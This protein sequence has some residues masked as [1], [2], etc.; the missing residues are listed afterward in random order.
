MRHPPP[1]F[2]LAPPRSFTS[3]V[4][5]AIGQHPELYGTPELNLFQAPTVHEFWTGR[6][7]D[8]S[9]RTPFWRIMRHDGILRALAQLYAGEQTMDAVE[10]AKRWLIVRSRRTTAEAHGEICARVGARILVDKSPGYVRRR[11]YLDRIV[12]AFPDARFIH[13]TRHPVGQCESVLSA[14]NGRL[15][16]FFMGAVDNSGA[17][18][19]IDPQNGW[20][21]AHH[22]ILKFLADIPRAR[23][24]RLKGE[25]FMNDIDGGAREVCRWLGVSDAA[26]AIEEMK[27]PE[28]SPFACIGPAG[29]R[30][31]NDP[32]FLKAPMLRPYSVKER[33]LEGPLPWRPDGKG[34][35]TEAI[36]LARYLG[37]E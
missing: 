21:D 14:D 11:E 18:P 3:L 20:R 16:A 22:T 9:L 8:G 29:A 35:S 19:V 17:E 10:M 27:H 6:L 7:P 5:G 34:F 25:D 33:T 15:T 32:N 26:A 12:A 37:Y 36:R 24:M 31:G 30:L 23:W 2:I 4:C 13:L 1:L 28:R